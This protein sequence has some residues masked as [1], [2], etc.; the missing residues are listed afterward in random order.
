MIDP[1]DVTRLRWELTTQTSFPSSGTLTYCSHSIGRALSWTQ[2]REVSEARQ[3]P[4][5]F[6]RNVSDLFRINAAIGGSRV[7]GRA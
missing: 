2:G 3:L 7:N 1:I 4:P 5:S 6:V